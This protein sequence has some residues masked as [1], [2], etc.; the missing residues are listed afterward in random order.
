MSKILFYCQVIG[1][2]CNRAKR[3]AD[4]IR[5]TPQKLE[6][7]KIKFYIRM[8]LHTVVFVVYIIKLI[9]N[10]ASVLFIWPLNSIL[11]CKSTFLPKCSKIPEPL[12]YS[13]SNVTCTSY[14]KYEFFN[15]E[16]WRKRTDLQKIRLTYWRTDLQKIMTTS[17]LSVRKKKKKELLK[18]KW[19]EQEE[20]TTK[21]I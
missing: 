18:P 8:I 7:T 16:H 3:G 1:V 4:D 14:H 9:L 2:C 20:T 13:P 15:Q 11:L 6:N 10:Y 5:Y 17:K 12:L 21:N 19:R